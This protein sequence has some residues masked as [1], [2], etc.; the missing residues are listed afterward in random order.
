VCFG[1]ENQAKR[2]RGVSAAAMVAEIIETQPATPYSRYAKA[3]TVQPG[4]TSAAA[5]GRSKRA[6]CESNVKLKD[7]S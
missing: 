7:F 4:W 1:F 3:V 2:R 5:G 6:L